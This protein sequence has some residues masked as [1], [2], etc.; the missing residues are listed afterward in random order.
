MRSFVQALFRIDTKIMLDFV[1]KS[2]FAQKRET[3]AQ[4]SLLLRVNPSLT[5]RGKKNE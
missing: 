2:N 4:E 3:V 1:K 5:E